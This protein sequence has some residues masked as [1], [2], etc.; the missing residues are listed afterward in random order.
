MQST[1]IETCSGRLADDV[2]EG[3]D[4][5]PDRSAPT[6]RCRGPDRGSRREPSARA[7]R[8]RPAP[9]RPPAGLCRGDLL[10]HLQSDPEPDQPLLGTVMKVILDPPAL[11]VGARAQALARCLERADRRDQVFW[12]RALSRARRMAEPAASSTSGRQH[13][14]VDDERQLLATVGDEAAR[15]RSAPIGRHVAGRRRHRYSTRSGGMPERPAGAA[16]RR[17]HSPASA[18]APP[19]WTRLQPG[20]HVLNGAIANTRPRAIRQ[21]Q[22]EGH[23]GDDGRHNHG[24]G[25]RA[26]ALRIQCANADEVP[27]PERAGRPPSRAV[28]PGCG[29]GGRLPCRRA[30]PPSRRSTAIASAVR[31]PGRSTVPGRLSARSA[32]ALSGFGRADTSAA[33]HEWARHGRHVGQEQVRGQQRSAMALAEAVISRAPAGPAPDRS[34]RRSRRRRS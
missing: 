31:A 8:H 18:A 32:T 22:G 20:D 17:T 7:G 34:D 15:C 4:R 16:G 14:I 6:D 30:A 29:A 23:R 28:A 2:G 10:E 21:R 11:L 5:D 25:G 1:R 19:G 26:G 12:S 27:V 33:A 13:R 9:E 3:V 24:R